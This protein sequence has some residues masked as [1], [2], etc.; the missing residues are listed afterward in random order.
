MEVLREQ[1]LVIEELALLTC[2][3]IGWPTTGT[4]GLAD[5]VGLDVIGNTVWNF[6]AGGGDE[7]P[8]VRSP[9]MSLYVIKERHKTEVH[10]KLLMAMEQSQ[11]WIV[12]G[13]IDLG[14]LI[15]ADHHDVLHNA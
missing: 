4:Y 9:D 8:D 2:A 6:E 11:A 1:D 15:A 13:K 10:V 5:M 3:V 12:G 7:R 14:F